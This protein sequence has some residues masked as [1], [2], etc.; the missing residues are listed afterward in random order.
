MASRTLVIA[1]SGLISPLGLTALNG[2][3]VMTGYADGFMDKA[4]SI[5]YDEPHI[6][7]L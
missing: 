1:P 7:L 4:R 6:V 2:E 3:I 5:E